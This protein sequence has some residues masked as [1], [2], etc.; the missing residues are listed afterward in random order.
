MN[1]TYEDLTIDQ[2]GAWDDLVRFLASDT[3]EVFVVEGY[4]GTGK[5]TLV[6][7]IMDCI[8][9]TLQAI[10]LVNPKLPDY[11]LQL[12]ATTN[13]AADALAQITGADVSTIHSHLGLRVQTDYRTRQTT[14]VEA[15]KNAAPIMH[16][17]LFVDEASYMDAG[18]LTMFFK[19]VKN[20]KVVFMGDPAQLVDF[21]TKKAPVFL[22]PF[23]KAKL[24]K[25]M[26]QAAG[27]PILDLATKFRE[28]V[29]SGQFFSFTPDGHHIQHLSQEDFEREIITEFSRDDWSYS[30]SKVLVWTN[31]SVEK[32]N[33]G[34][35][36]IA[37]G[38][39]NFQIGDYVQN[40]SY[41]NANKQSLKTDQL[42]RITE[43]SEKTIVHGVEGHYYTVDG[44]VRAFCA[45]KLADKKAAL[46]LAH[47][48]D[49]M[50]IVYDIEEK[51]IDL[52]AVYSHTINKSQGSTYDK[53]FI[54]LN[55]LKGC[56]CGETLARLLYVATSRARHHVY[57]TGDLV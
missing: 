11:Q 41:F 18:L 26:R 17:L 12:T 44:R 7:F 34:I 10:R 14:L 31:K 45:E 16:E 50:G 33:K 3:E 40:N 35:S 29:T 38:N 37:S 25:V 22:A 9:K 24:T 6:R 32:Y 2:Q 19:R 20:C 30:Q 54:D 53:V 52:R 51:W 15:N 57:F 56:N 46:K 8:T 55:D 49:Q 39:S 36:T 48:N 27:N 1:M 42:V 21:K 4:A 43:V 13:K 5:S 47:A 28:T 23:P